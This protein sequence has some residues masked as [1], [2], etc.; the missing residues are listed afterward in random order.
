MQ[1]HKVLPNIVNLLKISKILKVK[2]VIFQGNSRFCLALVLLS[3]E[4][5]KTG[6]QYYIYESII[7]HLFHMGNLKLY[8]KNDQGFER[9]LSMVKIPSNDIDMEFGLDECAKA[10]LIRRTWYRGVAVV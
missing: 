4:L 7:N 5:G 6:Y 8:G 3:Y 9:L 2:C 1:L 10:A